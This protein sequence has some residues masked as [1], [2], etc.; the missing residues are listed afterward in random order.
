MAATVYFKLF[1]RQ[2]EQISLFGIQI[3]IKL[4]T[5]TRAVCIICV[6][7]LN[8]GV[9]TF[10]I[11]VMTGYH[12]WQT[13]CKESSHLYC[14]CHCNWVCHHLWHPCDNSWYPYNWCYPLCCPCNLCCP[15]WGAL[16]PGGTYCRLPPTETMFDLSQAEISAFTCKWNS[17]Q[18][19]KY[20]SHLP[21]VSMWLPFKNYSNYPPFKFQPLRSI[22]DAERSSPH[23]NRLHTCQ[24]LNKMKEQ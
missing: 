22:C 10:W 8:E 4:L 7:P 9:L 21:T 1:V 11:L 24:N 5:I 19:C 15:T 18:W 6:F 12:L 13:P 23:W 16:Q 17:M 20:S 14:N 3:G 2:H